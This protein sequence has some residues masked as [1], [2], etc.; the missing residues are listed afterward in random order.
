ME[1]DGGKP[2][3]RLELHVFFFIC[4]SLSFFGYPHSLYAIQKCVS[5]ISHA[6]TV[7]SQKTVKSSIDLLVFTFLLHC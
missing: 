1:F 2:K 4:S 3:S 6:Q 7:I 5:L